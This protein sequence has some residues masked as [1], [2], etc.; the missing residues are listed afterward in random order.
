MFWSIQVRKVLY[1]KVRVH[2]QGESRVQTEEGKASREQ[3]GLLQDRWV[4]TCWCQCR[5]NMEPG[6]SRGSARDGMLQRVRKTQQRHRWWTS[7]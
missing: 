2:E 4:W 5:W 7:T 6:I 1:T 3:K